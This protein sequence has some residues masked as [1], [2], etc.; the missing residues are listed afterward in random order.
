MKG[1]TYLILYHIEDND[2]LF[3]CAIMKNYLINTLKIDE[4]H[5]ITKGHTYKSLDHLY[6]EI[7][8]D[9]GGFKSKFN[10]L[11]MTDISFDDYH[12]MIALSK[13][14]GKHFTWIDHHAPIIKESI[15]NKFDDING[16]RDI[17]HSAL[18]NMWR[19]LYDPLD[20][21]FKNGNIPTIFKYLSGWD[22]W[23][24]KYWNLTLDQVRY[25]NT[26]ITNKYDL[27]LDIICKLVYMVIY[28]NSIGNNPEYIRMIN[29]YGKNICDYEDKKYDNL[30][31]V[32]GDF[33][34][35]LKIDENTYRKCCAIFIQAATNSLM[36]RKAKG[37]SDNGLVFKKNKNGGWVLS[38]YNI[39]NEDTF[40]CGSF[41]KE[42]YNG[43]GHIGAAG[44]TITDNQFI[45]MINKKEI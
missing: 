40:D 42:K 44:A 37:K 16:L 24:Y 35:K 15:K 31:S 2:G 9:L 17:S 8:N 25:F 34:W 23:S 18:M 28:E 6:D 39:N 5:I 12:S 13:C 45:D 30:I 4:S 20:E 22:S 38:L 19:Y 36:F 11:I 21:K 32:F 14:Y 3:S 43:G 10:N 41:L 26:G 27:D 33:D 29:D 7:K 1:K